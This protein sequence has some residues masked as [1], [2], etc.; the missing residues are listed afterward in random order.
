[1]ELTDHKRLTPVGG[2]TSWSLGLAMKMLKKRKLD[3]DEPWV[4]IYEEG[5]KIIIVKSPSQT[6]EWPDTD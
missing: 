4:D 6:K 5:E 3:K 1:M 2:G